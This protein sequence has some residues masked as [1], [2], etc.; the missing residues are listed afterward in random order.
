MKNDYDDIEI[1][2]INKKRRIPSEETEVL[3]PVVVK[4]TINKDVLNRSSSEYA[5]KVELPTRSSL[6]EDNDNKKTKKVKK[7][8]R[9]KKPAKT[10]EKVFWAISLTFILGC[11]ILYGSRLIHYYKIYNPTDPS[12]NRVQLIADE[13]TGKSE[14]VYEGSGLYSNENGYIYKGEVENNY[15]KYNNMLWRIV[16][17]NTDGTIVIVL[18]DSM[19]MLPWN[20]KAV[21]YKDSDIHNYLNNE[22]LGQLDKSYLV[23]YSFCEDSVESLTSISCEKKNSDYYVSL[24]DVSSFLNS[25]IDKKTYLVDNWDSIFWLNNYSSDKVWHTNEANVSQSDANN[26]YQVRPVVKLKSTIAYVSG[27]GT[28][29]NPYLTSKED[30]LSIGSKVKLGEDIWIVYDTT[31]GTK[32]MLDKVLTKTYRYDLDKL[33]YDVSS[34]SSLAEYLNT[35][36]LESL[37]YKDLLE[38]TDWVTGGYSTSYEDIKKNTVK[39]KVGIPTLLD[40]QFDSSVTGYFTSTSQEEYILVYDNPIHASKVTISRSIRPCIKLTEDATKKLKLNDGVYA[41]GD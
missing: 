14:Y 22:F 41:M 25:I 16:K 36:Y 4:K 27:D 10:W 40:Y 11:C 21:N 33:T 35:E 13:I 1:L 26:F 2:D 19:T 20:N 3:D 28:K 30:S 8:G 24:L 6:R 9:E 34:K 29:E 31:N 15:L 39:A 18:E 23:K 32:L 12:G 7:S 17:I 37:S 5:K 38:E